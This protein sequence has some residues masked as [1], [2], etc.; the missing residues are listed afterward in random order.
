MKK[1]AA[2]L[3]C[4][5]VIRKTVVG[6]VES[7]KKWGKANAKTLFEKEPDTREHGFVVVTSTFRTKKCALKCWPKVDNSDTSI[8]KGGSTSVNS[9]RVPGYILTRWEQSGWIRVP[10]NEDSVNGLLA[11]ADL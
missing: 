6:S 7:L 11:S 1:G 2:L 10:V 4:D 5:S 3:N 8:I 9:E